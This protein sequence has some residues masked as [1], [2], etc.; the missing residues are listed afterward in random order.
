MRTTDFSKAPPVAQ[1]DA[2]FVGATRYRGPFSIFR[3]M[4]VWRKLIRSL[5]H[6]PGYNWHTIYYEFPF[7]LGTIA[8]FD[9]RENL[10]RFA[11]TPEHHD[12]MI[13]VT[14]DKRH[15][16]GGYIR[17]YEALPH[18]Y[19]NGVWRAESN[20]MRHIEKFTAIDNETEGPLVE[21]TQ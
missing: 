1:A 21:G 2:M 7:T 15:A 12:L 8:F 16:T 13:W 5:K 6:S 18:G 17:I 14:N 4:R 9:T 3:V 19:T 10:I 20:E 11:R